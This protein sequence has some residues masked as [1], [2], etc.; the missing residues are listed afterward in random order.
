MISATG[1]K[2]NLEKKKQLINYHPIHDR[3]TTYIII[4]FRFLVLK[5]FE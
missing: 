3:N 2:Y 4:F 5:Y 1:S